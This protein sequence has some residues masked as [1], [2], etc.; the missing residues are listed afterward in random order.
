M[1]M[2]LR[3]RKKLGREA[4]EA[5]NGHL[6]QV[7]WMV[8]HVQAG[9]RDDVIHDTRTGMKRMRAFL[10]L[11]RASLGEVRYSRATQD[12]KSLAD[13]FSSSRDARALLD[14][15]DLLMRDSGNP[16]SWRRLRQ[17]FLSRYRL[18]IQ[19]GEENQHLHQA[20][21]QLR[22]MRGATGRWPLKNYRRKNLEAAVAQE[23][24]RGQ[25]FWQK[26]QK[27][28]QPELFH[29]WRKV[30]KRFYY[31]MTLLFPKALKKR[32][33]LYKDLG[34]YL[35]QLHDLHIFLDFVHEHRRL[36]W[37]ED[38]VQLQKA[39]QAREYQL[40]DAIWRLAPKAYR[41]PANLYAAKLMRRWAK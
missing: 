8:D 17:P 18:S 30:V 22:R 32:R 6:A 11:L 9:E 15:L 12:A 25:K 1:A 10:R 14:T 31:Q 29:A 23:Y 40:I 13:L 24:R 36:F 27:D 38:L 33:K 41:Q 20:S 21:R 35:G 5:V 16:D 39:A 34:E 4:L 28:P 26:I 2:V 19:R 37:N 7:N 3:P